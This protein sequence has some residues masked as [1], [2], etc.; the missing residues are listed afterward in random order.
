MCCTLAWSVLRLNCLTCHHIQAS[1]LNTQQVISWT[2]NMVAETWLQALLFAQ[3]A[4]VDGGFDC[5]QD[6]SWC[7]VPLRSRLEADLL[8]AATTVMGDMLCCTLAW[9]VLRRH[10]EHRLT[11]HPIPASLAQGNPTRAKGTISATREGSHIQGANI[12]QAPSISN[13]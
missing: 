2:R 8:R 11:C 7:V 13:H 10:R 6:S 1:L 12:C 3:V 9:L 4:R 5:W